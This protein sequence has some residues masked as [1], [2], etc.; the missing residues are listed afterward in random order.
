MDSTGSASHKPN[1][2]M[3]ATSADKLPLKDGSVME[4][5]AWGEEVFEPLKTFKDADFLVNVATLQGAKP[6]FDASSMS[7][8][9]IGKEKAQE[10]NELSAK[11]TELNKPLNLQQMTGED[12]A[13]YDAIYIAGGHGVLADLATSP[14]MGKLL[15]QAISSSRQVVCAVCHGP[16]VFKALYLAGEPKALAGVKMTGFSEKEE[17]AA[18]LKGRVPFELESTLK[19]MGVQYSQ[20]DQL[21]SPYI[22]SSGHTENGKSK[23][24]T[25]QNPASS[26]PLADA[27]VSNLKANPEV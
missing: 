27:I 11:S 12:L 9:M 15:K 13:K 1:I 20:T 22:V 21:F 18:S 6:A 19:E 16:A 24:I 5:G 14:E 23:F 25:G 8:A 17:A 26:K 10:Y 2:L 4:T 3:I 7:P